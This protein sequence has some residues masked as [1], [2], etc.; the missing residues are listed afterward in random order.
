MIDYSQTYL[1]LKQ[2]VD[3]YHQFALKKNA[4]MAYETAELITDLAQ[5]LED[6]SKNVEY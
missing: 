6:I 1:E 4:E 3:R 2:A 5:K